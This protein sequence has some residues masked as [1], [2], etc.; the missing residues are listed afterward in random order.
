MVT[1]APSRTR[2]GARIA[3]VVVAAALRLVGIL[4]LGASA[5]QGARASW[6]RFGVCFGSDVPPV[7]DLPADRAEDWCAYMQDH[8]Y[9]YFVPEHPWVPIADAAQQEGLSLMLL[10]AGLAVVS[11]SFVGRWF[12]WPASVVGGVG[13][14]A[15]WFALGVPVWRTG[16]A[17]EPVGFGDWLAA[18]SLTLFTL[19]ATAGLAVLFWHRGGRDGRVVAVFWVLMTLAQPLPELFASS[20]LWGS[21]DT[22]PL[23]GLFRCG[24]VAFAGVVVAVT[25]L[26]PAW[27]DRLVSRPLRTARRTATAAMSRLQEWGERVSPRRW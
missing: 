24:A 6:S 7:P 26:P 17:G 5:V 11:L 1:E 19:L 14:G 16:L 10:G 18:H 8:R 15:V 25:F 13:S 21:H 12:V 20:I 27:Q 23:R 22:S 2:R 9:D 4:L 3:G